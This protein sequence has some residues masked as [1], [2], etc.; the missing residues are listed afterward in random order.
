MLN[1]RH[2]ILF[3][4]L[5]LLLQKNTSRDGILSDGGYVCVPVCVCVLVQCQ[6]WARSERGAGTCCCEILAIM[7]Y[8]RFWE[9]GRCAVRKSFAAGRLYAM[10][11]VESCIT[12]QQLMSLAG[13]GTGNTR[14]TKRDTG[15]CLALTALHPLKHLPAFLTSKYISGKIT[16]NSD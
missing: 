2:L 6:I 7:W 9:R 16:L 4:R 5:C 1:L 8:Y 14:R 15:L 10:R 12:A 11:L 13:W 3:S